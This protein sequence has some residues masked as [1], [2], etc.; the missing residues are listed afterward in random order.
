M[1]IKRVILMLTVVSLLLSI[2]AFAAKEPG[3]VPA[4]G[5]LSVVVVGDTTVHCEWDEVTQAVKYSVD[6][7]GEVTYWMLISEDPDVYEEATAE[8]TIECGSTTELEMDIGID[9]LAEA[10]ALELGVPV[11]DLI[12]FDGVVKVKGLD[13]GK[14]KGRQN[15]LFATDELILPPVPE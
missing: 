9:E 14:D 5:N 6:V 12:S 10:A 7:E 2:T 4:P 11:E 1:K 15:N 13:P 3:A 8:I